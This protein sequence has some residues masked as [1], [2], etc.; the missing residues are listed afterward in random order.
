MSDYWK[1][2]D[3]EDFDQ[4][5]RQ[6]GIRVFGWSLTTVLAVV[7]IIAVVFGLTVLWAPWKGEAD[8]FK[9]QQSGNNR[10]FQQAFFEDTYQEILATDKKI[11]VAA[12]AVK[13]DPSTVNKT[14]YTGLV[15][16]CNDVVA[17]YNAQ[18]RKYLAA[19]FKSA[20][21][22]DEISDTNPATDCKESNA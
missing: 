9:K 12:D 10:I 3:R 22:P 16:Y 7:A 2:E 15:N 19:D 4:T 8:A 14:N 20:D 1:K 18:A 5:S 13:Q 6:V 11:D 21:L 17:D